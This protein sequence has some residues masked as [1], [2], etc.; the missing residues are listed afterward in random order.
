VYCVDLIQAGGA[1]HDSSFSS[2]PEIVKSD[3]IKAAAAV[4]FGMLIVFSPELF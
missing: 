2:Y 3:T 4:N 1:K